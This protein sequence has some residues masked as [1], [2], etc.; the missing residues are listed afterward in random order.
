MKK[1]LIEM[2]LHTKGNSRCGEVEP[3][4][5]A[6]IYKE[7]GY[8]GIVVTNHFSPYFLKNLKGFTL[9]AKLKSYVKKFLELRALCKG[10]GINVL[11]GLELSPLGY[12][13]TARGIPYIEYLI[14]GIT[15]EDVDKAI[16]K[17]FTMTEKELHQYT[18]SRGWLLVQAHPY[19]K[20]CV[21]VDPSYLDGIEVF[22]G[23]AGHDSNNPLA[24]ER[25]AEYDLIKTAGSDYHFLGGQGAGIYS[26]SLP[27]TEKE[28][29]EI[30]KQR[31][32]LLKKDFGNKKQKSTNE[33]LD[34]LQKV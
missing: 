31:K 17:L 23:H 18:K 13:H 30:L 6:R 2:H 10:L 8:D 25:A 14:Y 16:V 15:V 24:E 11:F 32:H 27:S 3:K 20:D 7:A 4:D 34:L 22:N 19:R 9:K 12:E 5:I 1:H 29:V 33:T 26:D 21:L 28:L